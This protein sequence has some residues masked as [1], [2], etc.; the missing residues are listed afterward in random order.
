MAAALSRASAANTRSALKRGVVFELLIAGLDFFTGQG[1]EAVHPELLAA[2]AAHDGTVDYGAAQI[3]KIDLAVG[4]ADAVAGQIADETA[5]EAIARPGGVED[6]FQQIARDHEMLA[7]AEQN[8]AILTA[9]NHQSMRT[10]FHNPG[11][12][13]A[14]VVFV[15]EQTGFAIVDQQEIPLLEGFEQSRAEIVDP[16]VHGVPAG[17]LDIA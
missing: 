1:A 2:E 3:G 7:L 5:G 8:R 4:R 11:G 10:H 12:G 17:E 14:Q 13:A 16:V 15:R 9:L 6:V